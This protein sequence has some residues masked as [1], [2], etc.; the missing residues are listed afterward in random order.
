MKKTTAT[1]DEENELY[2][3]TTTLNGKYLGGAFMSKEEVEE[4]GIE[5]V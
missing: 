3:V 1:Y 5:I 4:Y 2:W